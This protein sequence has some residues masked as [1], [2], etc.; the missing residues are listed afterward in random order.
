MSLEKFTPDA[1]SI[2]LIVQK[3][4]PA[5]Y[6]VSNT[7]LQNTNFEIPDEL[8]NYACQCGLLAGQIDRLDI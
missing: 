1:C 2:E 4:L 3:R 5:R 8:I 6:G 7:S